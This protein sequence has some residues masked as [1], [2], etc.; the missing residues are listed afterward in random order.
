[1]KDGDYIGARAPYGYRKDPDNCHKLLIDENTAPV[2]KQILNGHMS[3][4]L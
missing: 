1:M 4:C 3:M 2:V